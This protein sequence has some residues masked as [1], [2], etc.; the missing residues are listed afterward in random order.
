MMKVFIIG[1]LLNLSTCFTTLKKKKQPVLR[2]VNSNIK[3]FWTISDLYKN[4][5]ENK[6][7][8]AAFLDDGSKIKVLDKTGYSHVINTMP[9]NVESLEKLLSKYNIRYDIIPSMS[10]LFRFI[11]NTLPPVLVGLFLLSMLRSQSPISNLNGDQKSIDLKQNIEVTFDDVA[12]CDESKLEL[13][14][15]VDFLKYPE[16]FTSIGAVSPKGILLEGPPGTGKTLLARAVAGEAGVPFIS[17]SGSQFVEMF[18]GVGASR[19]RKLFKDAKDNSPCIIFIDEIDSIGKR[20]TNE[21]VGG[22]DERDQT[23]N[24]ILAEMDGFHGNSGIIILAAT[25]RADILDD[26]LLR[27]GRF[28]RRIPVT[29]PSKKG[30]EA[31]LNIHAK[32]KRLNDSVDLGEIA[33]R[34][35]GF[36]GASL[37]NVMNE[38]AIVAVRRGKKSIGPDE[39]DYSIDRVTVGIQKPIGENV[40]KELVAYHEA[41]H[42]VMAALTSDYDNVT[43][44]TIIPRTNGAGGF[45]LFTPSEERIETGLYSQKYLKS[46]LCVA[47]GGRVAEELIFGED[48]VTTGASGDLQKVKNLARRM[49]TEWGFR[50]ETNQEDFPIAWDNTETSCSKQTQID[51]EISN[52]VKHAYDT[53][54][55]T[56]TDNIEILKMVAEELMEFETISGKVVSDIVKSHSLDQDFKD[57]LKF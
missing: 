53:C 10:P 44:V 5:K 7:E 16:N 50:N 28:D 30:R 1:I 15:V 45:T 17:A 49:I 38:A 2:S 18:V 20:R 33:S 37:K 8:I 26:A 56:L 14:E 19:V 21:L 9:N 57:D 51:N 46:Q 24:Q 55:R 11:T 31:I 6:V 47:L 3:E 40:R 39:L 48:E 35:I 25:N 54:K 36:S 41:G 13:K 22:N 4:I 29:L 12:G 34:T 23:L 42:A 52:I 43:K 27:P 32:G